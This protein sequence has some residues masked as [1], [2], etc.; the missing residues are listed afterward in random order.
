MC[1]LAV[2]ALQIVSAT[3]FQLALSLRGILGTEILVGIKVHKAEYVS[4]GL[5]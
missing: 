3:T 5:A 1:D 2:V 4:P